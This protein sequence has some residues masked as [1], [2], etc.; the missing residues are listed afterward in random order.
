[1]IRTA[2]IF[3]S[4]L[5]AV[6]LSDS[7][8]AGHA[9]HS[10]HRSSRRHAAGHSGQIIKKGRASHLSTHHTAAHRSGK[11]HQTAR[12]AKKLFAIATKLYSQGKLDEAIEKF[13]QVYNLTKN[14]KVLANIAICNAE[15]HDPVAAVTYWRQALREAPP[16]LTERMQAAKPKAVA[17][18]EQQVADLTVVGPESF[19][20]IRI[21]GK[22]SGKGTVTVLLAAGPHEVVLST[23][24]R[25]AMRKTI[26]VEGG[27]ARTWKMETW[28]ASPVRQPSRKP[29]RHFL[30]RIPGYYFLAAAAVTVAAG[31][32][33]IGVGIKTNKLEDDYHAHPSVSTRDQGLRHKLATNALVGILTVSAVTSV[34]VGVFTDWKGLGRLFGRSDKNG[35]AFVI[36][37]AGPKT[38]G[39]SISGTY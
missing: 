36:P 27:H 37:M 24:G 34:V 30:G 21:D 32:A 25:P 8:M 20:A 28:P 14:P 2:L 3:L 11:A 39:I 19:V 6:G 17:S 15:K 23:E 22:Q 18:A 16:K 5:A 4:S 12:R 13:R 9:R 29:R 10:K 31:A 35:T 38:A 26:Q 33:L 7:A 1:M